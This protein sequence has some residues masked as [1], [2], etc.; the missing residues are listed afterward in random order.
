MTSRATL[1]TDFGSLH[2]AL[3]PA[4]RSA[5]LAATTTA[6]RL[7]TS[8]TLAALIGTPHAVAVSVAF[9][10][11]HTSPHFIVRW[12]D[13]GGILLRVADCVYSRRDS[14]SANDPGL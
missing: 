7:L 12:F 1:A 5:T 13:S 4:A 11:C 2:A 6:A 14:I 9:I 3:I 8:S 10:R